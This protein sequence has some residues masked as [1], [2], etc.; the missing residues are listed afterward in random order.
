MFISQA[1]NEKV[2]RLH[3]SL[4]KQ[5]GTWSMKGAL[6]GYIL[7]KRSKTE[8]LVA[9]LKQFV[10]WKGASEQIKTRMHSSRMHTD[11]ALTVFPYWGGL[12]FSEKWEPPW[13]MGPPGEKWETPLVRRPPGSDHYPLVIPPPLP[14]RHPPN[15]VG[16][17][18]KSQYK[19]LH[20]I[21]CKEFDN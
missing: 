11:C 18:S 21:S 2:R 12:P 16:N 14:V 7:V 4:R 9:E 17:S 20:N 6:S 3:W 8:P 5:S 13:I 19:V 15:A 10:E 1:T